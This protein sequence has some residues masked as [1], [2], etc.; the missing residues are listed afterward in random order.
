[1]AVP[2]MTKPSPLFL[3]NSHDG[4]SI[5]ALQML[6]SDIFTWEMLYQLSQLAI[7]VA[8]EKYPKLIV[9]K[10]VDNDEAKR[11][12]IER[13]PS[14]VV[15]FVHSIYVT[16]RGIMHL[17][18][19]WDASNIDKLYIAREGGY[20]AAHLEVARTNILFLAYLLYD[21]IHIVLQYPKL[22]GMDTMLH[23]M[24]FAFCSMINGTY[25]IM[26]FQ[27][28][29]L[30]TGELSTIFLNWRWFLLKSG[31][32]SGSLIENINSMFAASFFSS[33]IVIYTAGIF[34]LYIFSVSELKSLSS[35]E[36]SG[37]P[38]SALGITCGCLILGWV[39]N[40]YWGVKIAKK[41]AAKEDKVA[42]VVGEKNRR[43]KR[44]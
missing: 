22:G 12:L 9:T 31:R 33:R 41:V 7:K 3:E 19:L 39:L 30:I 21:M 44:D 37:V 14:Y 20:R 29:W 27:F 8:F 2:I 36:V 38:V 11:T 17:Y 4:G 28:G 26:P 35:P 15:S 1:M 16:A 23:H 5:G 6:V 42:A 24:L 40:L 34:H 18:S 25:G 10:K 13:G 43:G 32:D